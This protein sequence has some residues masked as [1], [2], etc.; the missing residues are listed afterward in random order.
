VPTFVTPFETAG[1]ARLDDVVVLLNDPERASP[2]LDPPVVT[3][4]QVA[5]YAGHSVVLL[6][7]NLAGG[8]LRCPARS[9]ARRVE[10]DPATPLP[11]GA[12]ELLE[13]S[14][15]PFELAGVL[16]RL[17]RGLPTFYA[18]PFD[19]GLLEAADTL[20]EAGAT[21]ATPT[22]PEPDVV[23]ALFPDGSGIAPFTWMRLV[24]DALAAAGDPAAGAWDTF[25]TSLYAG[26]SHCRVLDHAGR[27][28]GAG[29]A[30]D[31]RLRR[32]SNLSTVSSRTV[33][34]G[35]DSDLEAALAS[36]PG[37]PSS[38]FSP[39]AGQHVA[40]RWS[41]AP[42]DGDEPLPVHAI[43]ETGASAAPG[44][45]LRMPADAGAL[46]TLQVLELAAW[47]PP[48]IPGSSVE[49]FRP[50]SRVEPLVDG[51]PTFQRLVADLSSATGAGFG[52]H[53]QGWT[54]NEF[55]LDPV[56]SE[57]TTIVDLAHA[58][59]DGGG[60]V[61][62]LATRFVNLRNPDL[63]E[64]RSLAVLLLVA[65]VDV[66]FLILVIVTL[67]ELQSDDWVIFAW[68]TLPS[69]AAL[70]LLIVSLVS[71][72]EGLMKSLF[73]TSTDVVEAINELLPAGAREIAIFS[74]NPMSLSD[75]PLAAGVS[76]PLFGIEDD[77]DQFSV[78]HNKCQLVRR[79]ADANGDEYVA[80]LGGIDINRNRFDSAGHGI[81]GPYHDVHSR[82]TGPVVADFFASFHER[83][84]RDRTRPD[85]DGG[86]N[87]EDEQIT[88]PDATSLDE[89][90]QLHIARAG[91]T[92]YGPN[93]AVTDPPLDFA[94]D[95]DA[96]IYLTLLAAIEAA[97]D[98]IYIEEQYFT[99][100]DPFIDKL[101][102]A[103]DHCRRLLIVLPGES[104]QPFGDNRRRLLLSRLRGDS[105]TPGWGDRMLVGF[106]QRRPLLKPAGRIASRGRCS[107]VR[108]CEP[109]DDEV[110]LAS[111]ARVIDAPFWLWIDGEL[112]LAGSVD[113]PVTEDGKPAARVAVVR[114]FT[115]G[116]PR[117]SAHP[118]RHEAGAPVTFS[119]VKGIYV[120]AKTM[121]IDDTFVSI[122]S[123][124]LNRRGFFSDGE[125]NV[126]AIPQQLQ[127]AADNPA[128]A[129]RC[130]LWAE[131]LGLST[132]MGGALLRDP[133]AAFDLFLRPRFAGNRFTPLT[134][135]EAKSLLSLT[136]Q[137]IWPLSAAEV[138]SILAALGPVAATAFFREIW[139]YVVDPPS[140]TDPAPVPGPV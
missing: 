53:L 78:W 38:L 70:L 104:D 79:T 140:E 98:Y 44:E 24:H 131:H 60:S 8:V 102:A 31:V 112:M 84:V 34:L 62:L 41:G 54:F 67:G 29:P 25:L 11:S 118:R 46:L 18:G 40:L 22:P 30:F 76:Q 94:E 116:E 72:F 39:P 47:Y 2:P 137:Q 103:K 128:R 61:R 82:V 5:R 59:L 135:S 19:P 115:P 106:P 83:W 64:L 50:G 35:A 58:V 51:I 96:G 36:T 52:T 32:D 138:I 101:L 10:L 97:Q 91:R 68:M 136:D 126:F 23:G 121:M 122:G 21:L 100:D 85:E 119:S 27:P 74:T 57:E 89:R 129:L 127:A 123:A 75:N 110:I 133:I 90:D 71:D 33:D 9:A 65:F 81:A 113:A 28:L 4:A 69:V 56:T 124:N 7:A 77:V 43:Y 3:R 86:A 37:T 117:W 99:P 125:L 49:R 45:F 63:D 132:A 16:S 42:P 15:L 80:Y 66:S 14:P 55:P 130:A 105:V 134:A 26:R 48:P 92:Y 95:G 13:L 87:A 1:V 108:V 109:A 139:N 12:T 120:H 111:P 88:V 93:P 73:E 17:P 107:L 20:I 6:Q 114:G